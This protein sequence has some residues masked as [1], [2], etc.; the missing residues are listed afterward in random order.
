[1]DKDTRTILRAVREQGFTLRIT[2]KGHAFITKDGRPVATF[3]GTPSDRRD[4][5]N[6]IA[7]LRRAGLPRPTK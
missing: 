2:G 4:L 5:A 3:S 1:M 7:A 6:S